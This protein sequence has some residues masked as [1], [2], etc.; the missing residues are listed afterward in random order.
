MKTA[1]HAERH[2][3]SSELAATIML[4]ACSWPQPETISH[5]TSGQNIDSII[6]RKYC[7][8]LLCLP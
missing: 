6:T 2:A 7:Y 8:E 3:A 5:R 1:S 4:R